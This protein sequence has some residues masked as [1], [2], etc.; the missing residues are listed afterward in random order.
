MCNER[1]FY[2]NISITLLSIGIPI[3]YL[4]NDIFFIY[5]YFFC[6][7]GIFTSTNNKYVYFDHRK[8]INFVNYV[9][10][11]V[12]VKKIFVNH[13]GILCQF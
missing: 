5:Y 9:S 11:P 6:E 1:S 7:K 3:N 13:L 4:C 2:Q 8:G 12:T 10:S